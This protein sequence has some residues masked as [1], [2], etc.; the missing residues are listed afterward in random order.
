M[1]KPSFDRFIEWKPEKLFK[2]NMP[3]KSRI[4]YC[5]ISKCF[6]LG[7]KYFYNSKSYFWLRSKISNHIQNILNMYI[8]F[9]I[10]DG[11]G[12]RWQKQRKKPIFGYDF[13]GWHSRTKVTFPTFFSNATDRIARHSSDVSLGLTVWCFVGQLKVRKSQKYF[14]LKLYC[15]KSKQFFEGF[16]PWPLKWIKSNELGHFLMLNRPNQ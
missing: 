5:F 2:R 11:F 16:L 6:W 3:A 12:I 7:S 1:P 8:F 4:C 13:F 9:Q 14:F 10:T 15:P